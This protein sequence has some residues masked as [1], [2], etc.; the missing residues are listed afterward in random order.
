MPMKWWTAMLIPVHLP[1]LGAAPARLSLWYVEP[2]ETVYEGDRLVEVVVNGATFDVSA[3]AA[4]RLVERHAYPRDMLATG[5][6]LGTIESEEAD[7][8]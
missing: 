7:G 8:P 6:L 5:Q 4:G 2:G 1:E 3:P